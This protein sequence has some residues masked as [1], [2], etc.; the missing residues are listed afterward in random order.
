[1]THEVLKNCWRLTLNLFKTIFLTLFICILSSCTGIKK[2]ASQR[3]YLYENH[4]LEA[5]LGPHSFAQALPLLFIY[6]DY[7]KNNR[8]V[9]RKDLFELFF[10]QMMDDHTKVLPLLKNICQKVNNIKSCELISHF[11][12]QKS[13][14]IGGPLSPGYF[15]KVFL[16][17]LII[18]EF[19]NGLDNPLNS[20]QKN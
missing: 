4:L 8:C 1:M 14:H 12:I 13:K 5:D 17:N 9:P 11:K 10:K 19:S 3:D 20:I 18:E 6:F 2:E 15:K 16:T 7:I